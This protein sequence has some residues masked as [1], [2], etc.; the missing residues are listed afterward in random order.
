M[1]WRKNSKG[2]SEQEQLEKS[3]CDAFRKRLQDH[4]EVIDIFIVSLKM[5]L[6]ASEKNFKVFKIK[7]LMAERQ[8]RITILLSF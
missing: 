3:I 1:N 5:I 7:L 8:P 4:Q 6:M 2:V